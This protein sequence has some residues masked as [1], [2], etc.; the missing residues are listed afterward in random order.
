ML[1]KRHYIFAC[2]VTLEDLRAFRVKS[3]SWR[4]CTITHNIMTQLDRYTLSY[5]SF[6]F[7]ILHVNN[8]KI[9]WHFVYVLLYAMIWDYIRSTC[10]LYWVVNCPNGVP[11]GS[12]SETKCRKMWPHRGECIE[13]STSQFCLCTCNLSE[14]LLDTTKS[15][16]NSKSK[17]DQLICFTCKGYVYESEGPCIF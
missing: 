7:G 17:L 6:Y 13:I 1:Q 11:L 9:K 5:L 4:R 16:L 15:S 8:A 3:Y 12:I 14:E 2:N 10:T